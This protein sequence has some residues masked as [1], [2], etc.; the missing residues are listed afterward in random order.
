MSKLNNAPIAIFAYNREDKISNLISSLVVC[1][2]FYSSKIFVFCDG[3][4]ND[5]DQEK[6]D[7]TRKTIR[8]RFNGNNNVTYVE[9]NE[10][11]GLAK[12]IYNGV[13]YVFELYDRLIVLEDDLELNKGFLTFMN[14]ALIKYKT[15][16]TVY[17]ISGYM[18]EPAQFESKKALLLPFISTWGWATWKTKWDGFDINEKITLAN[19]DKYKIEKFNLNNSY[20]FFYILKGTIKGKIDSWGILWYLYVFEKA[21]LVLYPNKSLII[22]KGFGKDATNTKNTKYSSIKSFN[23]CITVELPETVLVDKNIQFTVYNHIKKSNKESLFIK[24]LKSIYF[25]K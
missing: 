9:Q 25:F 7:K 1:D 13:N 8:E 6:V 19:W 14:S 17:Q 10:N 24:I 2:G 22:N 20:N 12:S 15:N 23:N 5:E 11:I 21:G 16:D 4:K 18:P 3:A